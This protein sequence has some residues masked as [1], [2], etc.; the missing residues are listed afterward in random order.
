[1][2]ALDG[3]GQKTVGV[4]HRIVEPRGQK[5]I[6]DVDLAAL[7]GVPTKALNQAMKRNVDRFPLDFAFRLMPSE[8]EVLRSQIVTSK[9]GSVP[10]RWRL[11]VQEGLAQTPW[12]VQAPRN[13]LRSSLSPCLK[14]Y[15]CS[16]PCVQTHLGFGR[17][18]DHESLPQRLRRFPKPNGTP[19]AF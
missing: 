7:Y 19:H 15:R 16:Q 14:P 6:L 13:R 1:M 17:G 3:R 18:R 5:V 12:S 8:T 4:E 11:I 2:K 10:W 9:S